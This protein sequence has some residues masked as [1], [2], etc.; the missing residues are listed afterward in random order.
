ML[1]SFP[2]SFKVWC[3]QV[4]LHSILQVHRGLFFYELNWEKAGWSCCLRLPAALTRPPQELLL[5]KV[6]R[7]IW[8][9]QGI[10]SVNA[11]T[12]LSNT[13]YVIKTKYNEKVTGFLLCS[14]HILLTKR[15]IFVF[16]FSDPFLEEKLYLVVPSIFLCLF[17]TFLFLVL[18]KASLF[19]FHLALFFSYLSLV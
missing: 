16:L 5:W 18:L 4:R 8:Q 6:K 9:V 7:V 1:S 11:A 12:S 15:N 17:C 14:Q 13:A 2:V 3:W 10:Y 19:V